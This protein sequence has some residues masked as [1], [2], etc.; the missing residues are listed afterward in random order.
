MFTHALRRSSS[1]ATD[2]IDIAE[3]PSLHRAAYFKDV[4]TLKEL[5]GKEELQIDL[6][7]KA[8]R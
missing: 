6:Q 3:L 7:D 2:R 5:L 1:S 8:G 4:S